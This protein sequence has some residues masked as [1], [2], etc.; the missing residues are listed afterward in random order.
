MKKWFVK[1]NVI[2]GVVGNWDNE[3]DL[4]TLIR[5]EFAGLIESERK[6]PAKYRYEEKKQSE[7]VLLPPRH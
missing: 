2:V 1:D 7:L 5:K 6:S 4:L 3:A